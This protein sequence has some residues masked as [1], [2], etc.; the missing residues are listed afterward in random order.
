MI[1]Y[2]LI[3]KRREVGVAIGYHLLVVLRDDTN[4]FNFL[5]LMHNSFYDT[6]QRYSFIR[7]RD[8]K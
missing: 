7:G 1:Y 5:I 4:I 8:A 2:I 6:L 3:I